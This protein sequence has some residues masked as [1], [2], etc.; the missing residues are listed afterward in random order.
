VAVTPGRISA[1]TCTPAWAYVDRALVLNPNLSTS[2][3]LGGFQRISLGEHDEAIAYFARAMRLSPFDPEIFQMQTGIAMGH[4]YSGRF[5]AAL[6]C[7]E[8]ASQEMLN[9]LR[10]A[11]FAAA[12][13]ALAGRLDDAPQAMAAD[14]LRQAGLPE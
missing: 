2:W 5:D 1:A 10:V 7:L 11:A 13:H 9:I 12:A 4:R 3:Y 14:G 6:S 8:K